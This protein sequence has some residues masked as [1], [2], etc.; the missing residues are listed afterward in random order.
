EQPDLVFGT[1]KE[2]GS[3]TTPSFGGGFWA[4][5]GRG[6]G[7]WNSNDNFVDEAPRRKG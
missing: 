1:F 3:S 7:T 6:F 4:S 2:G 5:K